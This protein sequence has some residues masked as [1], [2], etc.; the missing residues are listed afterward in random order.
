MKDKERQMEIKFENDEI[1]LTVHD[2]K[3]YLKIGKNKAYALFK[4]AD[5]PAIKIN[6]SCIVMKKDLMKWIDN[7]KGMVILV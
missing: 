3:E 2:V 7:H 5:F 6:N 4:Q 1:M